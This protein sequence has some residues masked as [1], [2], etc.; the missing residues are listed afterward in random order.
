MS[1]DAF[2]DTGTALFW[3][4]N[5]ADADGRGHETLW[6]ALRVGGPARLL[7]ADV[8]DLVLAGTED[9]LRVRGRRLEWATAAGD[10]TDVRSIATSGGAVGTRAVTGRYRLGPGSW[11]IGVPGAAGA[12]VRLYRGRGRIVD[13]PRVALVAG[14]I[15]AGFC[16]S[17]WKRFS[18]AYRA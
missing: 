18:L 5:L 8:G 10:H 14:V 11:L 12:P 2:A 16:I 13:V 17:N 3:L 9:D 4:R 1:F 15:H 6:T 7:A